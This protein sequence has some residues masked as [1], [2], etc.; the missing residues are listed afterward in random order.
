MKNVSYQSPGTVQKLPTPAADKW[1]QT[2][3]KDMTTS[4]NAHDVFQVVSG[5]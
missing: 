2:K 5:M 1:N 4:S 3:T